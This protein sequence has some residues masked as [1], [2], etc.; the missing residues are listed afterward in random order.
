VTEEGR[1]ENETVAT[2]NKTK[3]EEYNSTIGSKE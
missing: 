3:K 1:Q 2:C